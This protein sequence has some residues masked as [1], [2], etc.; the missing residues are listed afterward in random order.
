MEHGI[1]ALASRV[2]ITKGIGNGA[3]QVFD[4]NELFTVRIMIHST[5]FSSR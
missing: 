2:L 5:K 1:G 3:A 4:M